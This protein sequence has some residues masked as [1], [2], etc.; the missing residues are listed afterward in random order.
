MSI[1]DLTVGL[2]TCICLLITD[3][4]QCSNCDLNWEIARGDRKFKSCQWCREKSREKYRNRSAEVV[5]KTSAT[6]RYKYNANEAWRLQKIAEVS[7]LL[8]STV[9]CSAGDKVLKYGSLLPHKTNMQGAKT[10]NNTGD[11]IRVGR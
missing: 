4:I 3:V 6:A 8:K 9:V 1:T 5:Q 10:K 7:S 2:L 11:D